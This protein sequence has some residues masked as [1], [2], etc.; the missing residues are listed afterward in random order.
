MFGIIATGLTLSKSTES[1]N[2]LLPNKKLIQILSIFHHIISDLS[3][4]HKNIKN[5]S[6]KVLMRLK[7]NKLSL[8]ECLR[9]FLMKKW[10][11]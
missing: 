11:W 7:M 5:N 3:T 9:I 10:R 4:S 1:K 6:N 2:W 8:M